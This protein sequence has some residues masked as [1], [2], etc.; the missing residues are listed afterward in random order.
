MTPIL[1]HTRLIGLPAS[2]ATLEKIVVKISEKLKIK[3]SV[4]ISHLCGSLI[5]IKRDDH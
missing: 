4:L 3:I 2:Y 1:V 5:L